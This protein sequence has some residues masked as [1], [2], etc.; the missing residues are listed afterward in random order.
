MEKL[1]AY[2]YY[3]YL[4]YVWKTQKKTV[5]NISVGCSPRVS[6]LPLGTR[7]TAVVLGGV[8]PLRVAKRKEKIKM[9]VLMSCSP[10]HVDWARKDYRS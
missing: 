6:K 2:A 1:I 10:S 8:P 5:M 3:I 7:A 9:K 4:V